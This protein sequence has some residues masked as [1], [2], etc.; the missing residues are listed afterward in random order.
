[1][2]QAGFKTFLPVLEPKMVKN[3]S[4][5]QV[6]RPLLSVPDVLVQ[7]EQSQYVQNFI[8]G[9]VCYEKWSDRS[10]NAKNFIDE[11]SNFF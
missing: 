2:T 5:Q 10:K 11:N 1:M 4:I 6:K 8:L 9:G 3:S 7:Q